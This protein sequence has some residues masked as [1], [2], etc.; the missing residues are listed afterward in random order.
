MK[1]ILALLFSTIGL[2][3]CSQTTRAE[4]VKAK[5]QQSEMQIEYQAITRGSFYKTAVDKNTISLQKTRDESAVEKA[6]CSKSDWQSIK[7]I[8]EEINL[9][10]IHD[11]EAPSTKSHYDGAASATISI[12]IGDKTYTSSSFDHGNPPTELQPLVA[13]ILA[14]AETVEN[15]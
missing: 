12:T 11:L 1:I 4:A 9:E 14:L 7:E 10:T 5:E 8:T 3:G 13:K 2:K 6:P 15:P